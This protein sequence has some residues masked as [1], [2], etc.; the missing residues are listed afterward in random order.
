MS[1]M[2]ARKREWYDGLEHR[3]DGSLIIY[4]NRGHGPC[5]LPVNEI[6][7]EV[8]AKMQEATPEAMIELHHH[9]DP[10][11]LVYVRNHE[12]ITIDARWAKVEKE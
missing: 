3:I 12:I 8:Y 4:G 1:D 7:S 10:E 2:P 6:P 9:A 5:A 11:I